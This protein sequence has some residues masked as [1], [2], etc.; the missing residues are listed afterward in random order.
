MLAEPL[1]DTVLM[2]EQYRERLLASVSPEFAV[3]PD[4]SAEQIRLLVSFLEALSSPKLQQLERWVPEQVP[5]G[6]PID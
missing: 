5:S 4:L 6:L 3:V 1:R 2:D